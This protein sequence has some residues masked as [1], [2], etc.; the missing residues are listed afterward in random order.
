VLVAAV[1][2]GFMIIG[3]NF[4]QKGNREGVIRVRARDAAN[5]I[6][7]EVIDSISALGTASVVEGTRT[8]V[9]TRAFEGRVGNIEMQY[10]VL[11][12]VKPEAS[13][14]VVNDQTDYMISLSS[15]SNLSV[16]HQFA[17]QVDITVGWKFKNSDQSIN[18]STVI[19]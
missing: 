17:K 4:L 11:I 10:D 3:L 2:L 1:V 18:M 16:K 5:V 6:A 15:S 14:Q 19:R 13:A 12:D 7:Q 8:C 9:K